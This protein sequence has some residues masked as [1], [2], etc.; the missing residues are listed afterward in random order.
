[1]SFKLFQLLKQEIV[2]FLKLIYFN[3]CLCVHNTGVIM[4]KSVILLLFLCCH[5]SECKHCNITKYDCTVICDCTSRDFRSIPKHIPNETTDLDLS[6]NRL[7]LIRNYSFNWLTNLRTLKI[8]YSYIAYIEVE[9]F[10]GM[11][12]LKKLDLKFN[13]LTSDSLPKRIFRRIPHLITLDISYNLFIRQSTEYPESALR[14]LSELQVLY[15]SGINGVTFGEG[16][17][18]LINL[19]QLQ[20]LPCDIRELKNDTF[21]NFRYLPIKTML[22]RCDLKSIESGTLEQFRTLQSLTITTNGFIM[23]ISHLLLILNGLKDQNMTLIDFSSNCHI[24]GFLDVLTPTHF[25]YLGNICVRE[26]NLRDNHIGIIEKGSISA[27]KYIDCIETINL[28]QNK[29]YGDTLTPFELYLFSNLKVLDISQQFSGNIP[30]LFKTDNRLFDSSTYT[31][32]V[33]PKLE[34]LYAYKISVRNTPLAN[35]NFTSGDNVQIV[36]TNW[37]P[38]ESC[39]STIQGLPNVQTLRMSGFRCADLN[40]TMISSF[41]KLRFLE[42]KNALLGQGLQYDKNAEFLKGLDLLQ[43]V[44]FTGNNLENL[45]QNLFLSQTNSLSSINLSKNK[46]NKFPLDL[47]KFSKLKHINLIDNEITFLTDAEINDID[48]LNSRVNNKL[49]IYL[50]GNAMQCNC[51]TL[52]FLKWL[53]ET[54]VTLDNN[55]NYS[56]VYI[57]GSRKT[58]SYVYQ[59]THLLT[60]ECASKFWLI[61]SVCMTALLILIIVISSIAYRYRIVLQYWYLHMRRKFRLYSKLNDELENYKYNAFIAYHHDNYK[62]ACGPLLTFLEEQKK[63]TLCLHDRDFVPGLLIVDNIFESISQSRKVIFVISRSF[64]DSSW[65]N[66]ELDLARMQMIRKNQEILIVIL[67]EKIKMNEMPSSLLRIWENVTVLEADDSI[68]TTLIPSY[69]DL[70]WNRLYESVIM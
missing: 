67:L 66:Y 40:P 5:Y 33:P 62:W 20:L 42:S 61:F 15:I 16:F 27:M 55:G 44:D 21:I 43:M 46:F 14:D 8:R 2:L 31:F 37:I 10:S 64:L 47:S 23:K 28:S 7:K 29:I 13:S 3:I 22:L 11:V 36:D 26:V 52:K 39:N 18:S 56:C 1:M 54:H 70:F 38:F 57:D 63:L 68:A 19:S 32:P 30:P 58:T 12:R 50:H 9:A 34:K 4:I 25:S 48:T 6:Y 65:C 51:Q 69:Q 53:F 41:K 17:K 49:Q 59:N 45:H 60:V 35:M 24:P